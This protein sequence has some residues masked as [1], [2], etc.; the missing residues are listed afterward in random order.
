MPKDLF[1]AHS[2]LYAKYRPGYPRQLFEYIA[3]FAGQRKKAWDCA[4][5]N[6]QAALMLADF[7]DEVEASDISITQLDHAV[8]KKNIHYLVSPAEQTPFADDSFDLITV[9]QAYHWLDWE[10]FFREASRVGRQ[11]AVVAVWTYNLFSCEDE[12]LNQL[13]RHFYKDITGPYWDRARKYV[14]EGY[15]TIPFRFAP[16]PTRD[17]SMIQTYNKEAFI[18]YLSTWSGAQE[19]LKQTGISPL[20]LIDKELEDV[21]SDDQPRNFH[22]PLVLKIGSVQK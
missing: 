12:R 10:A 3:G 6:G 15:A 20:T 18:G 4:T 7:F 1:S 5:G 2:D 21:W 9:A 19:Y 17:F 22:F 14:E 13:I 8:P 11:G 16:L